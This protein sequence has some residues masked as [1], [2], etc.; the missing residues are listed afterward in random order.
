MNY[1]PVVRDYR[2]IETVAYNEV[3]RTVLNT[4]QSEYDASF[5]ADLNITK[6]IGE[7]LESYE[8]NP[9]QIVIDNW[10]KAIEDAYSDV[11]KS[12]REMVNDLG[13]GRGVAVRFIQTFASVVNI[14]VPNLSSVN[15]ASSTITFEAMVN[16]RASG[17]QDVYSHEAGSFGSCTFLGECT[18]EGGVS[19]VIYKGSM[20]LYGV[21]PQKWS[22]VPPGAWLKVTV[23]SVPTSGAASTV[24]T[25]GVD[26]PFAGTAY[27]CI[28]RYQ[29]MRRDNNGFD[30][31]EIGRVT[32][33]CD[34]IEAFVENVRPISRV[35][36]A[37]LPWPTQ[38]PFN[39]TTTYSP[40][41]ALLT[42]AFK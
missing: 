23:T 31:P 19:V 39:P 29:Q 36:G 11:T 12:T 21:F 22:W 16:S 35:Q 15:L 34:D 32:A 30:S 2:D 4:P 28:S 13:Y 26:I 18:M 38:I 40:D 3:L 7:Y 42:S 6:S 17:M 27:D 41:T 33:E 25:G 9:N 37:P 10:Q 1:V 24:T 8:R 5:L 14:A 20:V